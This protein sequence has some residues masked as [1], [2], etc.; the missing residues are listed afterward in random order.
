MRALVDLD[1]LPVDVVGASQREV[2]Q[3]GADGVVGQPVDDDESA[4][5]AVLDVRI[6]RRSAGRG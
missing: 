4:H 1:R 3:P 6:E 2:E 5:V